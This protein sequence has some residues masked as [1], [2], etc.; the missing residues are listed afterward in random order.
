MP[1]LLSD[2][3]KGI[4]EDDIVVLSQGIATWMLYVDLF[5]LGFLA[6]FSFVPE[7][8]HV[9]ALFP[10]VLHTMSAL[11]LFGSSLVLSVRSAHHPRF[12]SVWLITVLVAFVLHLVALVSSVTINGALMRQVEGLPVP[13]SNSDLDGIVNAVGKISI[14]YNCLL[15]FCTW[16]LMGYFTWR[17]YHFPNYVVR[18]GEEEKSMKREKGKLEAEDLTK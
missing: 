13:G 14:G 15:F 3:L 18:E 17:V 9:L 5:S 10:Q 7:F 1:K 8:R 12:R 6:Y 2:L 16:I 4:H 11:L